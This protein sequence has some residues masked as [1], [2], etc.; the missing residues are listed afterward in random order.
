M[1]DVNIGSAEDEIGLE[2]LTQLHPAAM[3]FDLDN[4]KMIKKTFEKDI[5]LLYF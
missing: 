3:C 1:I 2:E 4:Y 5:E